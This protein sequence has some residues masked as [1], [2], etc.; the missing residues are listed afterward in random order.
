M[1]SKKTV[2]RDI[3]NFEDLY[4]TWLLNSQLDNCPFYVF[5][6]NNSQPTQTK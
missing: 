5:D 4:K 2:D 3:E 1:K 6:D